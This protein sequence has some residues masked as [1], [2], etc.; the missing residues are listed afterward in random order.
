MARFYGHFA[1]AY[2]TIWFAL[3]CAA[4]VSQSNINTGEFGLYGFPVIAL[5]YAVFRMQGGK[6][7]SSELD[8]LR[9]RIA[10]L[11]REAHP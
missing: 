11:E 6:Q 2:G 4:I 8:A 5:A 9:R 1:A 3:M 7:N 10:R